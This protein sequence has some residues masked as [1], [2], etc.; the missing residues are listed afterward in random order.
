MVREAGAPELGRW[1]ATALVVGHTIGVGI[2][3]TPAE[4][5][6]AL[7]SPALTFGLWLACVARWFSPER[8]RS[9]SWRGGTR[10]VAL[11]T[12]DATSVTPEHH[13][14]L[15]AAG[16]DD[17]GILQ[18]TLIAAWFNYINRVADSLGVGRDAGPIP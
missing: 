13:A 9:G 2:F 5:I 18:I 1:S 4:L 3:L 16:F 12:K 7:A 8:S 6:G 14:R 17:R 11:L 10:R 15:R